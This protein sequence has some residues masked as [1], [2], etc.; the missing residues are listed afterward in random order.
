[1]TSDDYEV[2]QITRDEY[3]RVRESLEEE[4]CDYADRLINAG[5]AQDI[6]SFLITSMDSMVVYFTKENDSEIVYDY[7]IALRIDRDSYRG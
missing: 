7:A 4:A 5:I 6:V 2:R 1:M 3:I